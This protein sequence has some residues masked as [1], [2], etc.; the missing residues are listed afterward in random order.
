MF[1]TV[2]ISQINEQVYFIH[3]L[4]LLLEILDNLNVA[5]KYFFPINKLCKQNSC[6]T[7]FKMLNYYLNDFVPTM[8]K[9]KFQLQY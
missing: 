9:T 6:Y 2:E 3:I 7:L 8:F 1:N 4:W 5:N